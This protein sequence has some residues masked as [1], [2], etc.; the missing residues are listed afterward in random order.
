VG[1][2]GNHH[3]EPPCIITK[4]WKEAGSFP[5]QVN[6]YG[7]WDEH[8]FLTKSGDLGSV[9]KIGGV[10]YESLDNAGRDYTVKRLEAAFSSLDERTRL[11][12]I[13]FKRN[14][15]AIPHAEYDNPLVR[16]S[17]EQRNAFLQSKADRLYS[18]EIYWVVMIDG[19]YAKTGLLHALA[20]LPKQPR[21]SLRELHAL[22]S[23]SNERTLLYEQIERDRLRLQ[24]KVQSLSGQ[25]NDLTLV[26]L[27]GAEETLRILRRLVNFRPSKFQGA[28][29]YGAR[30]LDWQMCDSE[31]EAHR[32]YL[33]VDDDYVRVLTLKELPSETRPL[34]LQ[35]LF[36]VPGNFHVVTEWHPVDN[37]KAR[38]EIASRRRH[39]HNSKTSFVSNLQDRE[40]SPCRL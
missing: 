39:H 24:Q 36:D 14:R 3:K 21:S 27:P 34:L 33:R 18:I 9:L 32:G 22:F 28:R 19:S 6:L 7:F 31:L 15:P 37:A 13:L 26:E 16:A 1:A 35:G 2:H 38:K 29:L 17:V 30:Y 10:D 5:A 23:G 12:Q 40:S 8:C 25:L 4:D 11:Y 20:A